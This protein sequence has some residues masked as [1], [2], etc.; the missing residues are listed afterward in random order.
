MKI[1]GAPPIFSRI[2]FA[3]S[4]LVMV[5][6]VFI[7]V[8]RA[9][10]P[11]NIIP[12]APPKKAEKFNPKAD[13]SNNPSFDQLQ[14][15]HIKDVPDMPMGRENPFQSIVTPAATTTNSQRSV[16]RSGLRLAPVATNTEQG[17]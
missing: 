12:V 16:P 5:G 3:V 11:A 13:V 6:V 8:S 4:A 15:D 9:L 14:E 17:G 7:F 2:L 10:E 1:N